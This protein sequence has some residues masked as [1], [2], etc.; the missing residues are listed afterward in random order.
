MGDHEEQNASEMGIF[1]SSVS[2]ITGDPE[3]APLV[4]LDLITIYD[5]MAE[6]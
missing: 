1:T 3:L 6:H 5:R 2:I 4:I